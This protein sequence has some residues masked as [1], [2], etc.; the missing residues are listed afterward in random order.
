MIGDKEF[1]KAHNSF[2]E[3]KS[4]FLFIFM[5]GIAYILYLLVVMLI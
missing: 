4:V 2:G 3:V 1:M 5:L